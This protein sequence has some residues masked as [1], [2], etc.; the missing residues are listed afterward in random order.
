MVG[1]VCAVWHG[2]RVARVCVRGC[3]GVDVGACLLDRRVWCRSMPIGVSGLDAPELCQ[4]DT[5][6]GI[7]KQDR[8]RLVSCS[9]DSN[10][11]LQFVKGIK[12]RQTYSQAHS[13]T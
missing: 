5:I 10:T 12:H 4:S 2:V 11:G 8:H 6:S 1:A 9:L 13:Q 7:A 3:E